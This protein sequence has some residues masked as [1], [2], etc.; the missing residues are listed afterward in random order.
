M[1]STKTVEIKIKERISPNAKVWIYQASKPFTESEA[2]KIDDTCTT[3]VEK[4]SAHGN[5]LIAD[6]QL[7]FNQFICLFVDETGFSASGCSIDSSVHFIKSLEKEYSVSLLNR[8]DVAYIS[9]NGEVKIID[10]HGLKDAF[11]AGEIS[12]KT[13][14]FNNLI[15]TREEMDNNW[16]IPIS[17]SWQSRL[18]D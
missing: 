10:M 18:I 9:E 2:A 3:F 5:N 8:T 7:F 1:L 14:V 13:L 4:W 17:E 16:L 15:R 11:E 12:N 6:C